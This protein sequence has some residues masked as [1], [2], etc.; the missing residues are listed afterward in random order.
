MGSIIRGRV[1]AL[2]LALAFA[3]GAVLQACG[4]G[5]GG[6]A[7]GGDGGDGSA[8]A[9]PVVLPASVAIATT[10]RVDTGTQAHFATDVAKSSGLTFNWNFGDGSS[11]VGAAVDHAYAA[12]GSYQVQLT[13]STAQDSRSASAVVQVGAWS[14]VAGLSCTRPGSAGWCWQNA[15]VT[16]YAINDVFFLDATHAWAVGENST[17]LASMDGGDHW[18]ALPVDAA[19]PRVSLVE[20]RFVDA[21]QGLALS[22]QGVLLQTADGGATWTQNA[23]AGMP[24]YLQGPKTLTDDRAGRIVLSTPSGGSIASV[25]GGLTWS[26]VG[27]GFTP[28]TLATAADCWSQSASTLVRAPGC[29]AADATSLSLPTAYGSAQ[30][31][32]TG[33][34]ASPLQGLFVGM[35]SLSGPPGQ[36]MLAWSTADGGATWTGLAPAG[37]PSNASYSGAVLRL[38]DDRTGL[39]FTPGNLAA[40]WTLDGGQDWSTVTSSPLVTTP[41]TGYRATGYVDATTL[42]QSSTNH[43]SISSDRGTTWRDATLQAE[44]IPTG[45]SGVEAATVAH[46]ADANDYL[47]AMFHRYYATHDGGR[48]FTRVLGPDARDGSST[49]ATVVTSGRGGMVLTSHGELLSTTDTGHTWTRTDLGSGIDSFVSLQFTSATRGWMVLHGSLRTSADGGATWSQPAAAASLAN[50]SGTSWGDVDH[51]LAWSYDTLYV[52]ADSGDGWTAVALPNGASILAAAMTGPLTGALSTANGTLLFTQD[53]GATWQAAGTTGATGYCNLRR[54]A[55]HGL[56]CIA[57]GVDLE[58]LDDG[59]GWHAAGP[60]LGINDGVVDVAFADPRNGWL[61]TRL[62]GVLHTTDGGA[63]WT[64]QPVGGGMSLLAVAAVDPMTAWVVTR[65]GQILATATGG[66]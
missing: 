44:D 20:V 18:A 22:D 63:T 64:A 13:V 66:D 25:D 16:G 5:G 19:L 39:L 55:G 2:A 15:I 65:D 10:A 21:L 4:G 35:Q 17:I 43:V 60:A 31:L 62:G 49:S 9:P 46:Y 56:W 11:G 12:P 59:R 27:D 34:F 50:L 40:Y 29:G 45:H 24:G 36:Q 6:G 54:V 47:L 48:T 32:I 7:G 8:P 37:L 3:L 52:T 41:Y 61:V 51:G 38:A 14:S 53:G 26:V 42:W 57:T 30:T 1:A 23:F 33:A 58:S 28:F